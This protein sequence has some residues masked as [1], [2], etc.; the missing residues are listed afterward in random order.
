MSIRRREK[1]SCP[2]CGNKIEMMI[3]DTIN[4]QLSP[5]AREALLHGRIHVADCPICKKTII[6]NNSILYHDMEKKFFVYYFPFES[7]RDPSFF[8]DFSV[9]GHLDL[10]AG[11]AEEEMPKYAKNIHFVFG[12]NELARYIQF[13]EKL[14]DIQDA[15]EPCT[16][17]G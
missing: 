5:E 10:N 8:D 16:N 3:W 9:D 14:A 6:V 13:R 7:I 17:A 12:V 4:A 11:L 2:Y 15:T 1:V